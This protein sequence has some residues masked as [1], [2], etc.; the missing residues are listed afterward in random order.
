MQPA[1]KMALR[2]ARQGSEFLK[3]HFERQD[4]AVQD[5]GEA[6]EQLANVEA[7]ISANFTEQL[8]KAY[9]DHYIAPT[10]DIEADGHDASWHVFPVIG[11]ENF[12]RGIPEFVT[13]LVQKKQG[14]AEHLLLINP[15]TGEEYSVSRGHGAALNSRRIRMGG[16]RLIADARLATNVLNFTREGDNPLVWGELITTLA[17]ESTD[18]QTSRCPLLDIARVS[19][20]HLDAAVLF[21][22]DSVTQSLGLLLAHESGGLSGD[23]SGNPSSQES[24]QLV[25]ANPKLFKDVLKSLHSFR[26]RLPR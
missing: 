5:F 19:A 20:G 2:I 4:P 16:A 24:R 8:Q 22:P 9:K 23:F 6:R 15:V 17:S 12:V 3:A 10:G 1:I 25:I 7:S 26:G 14:R 18:V 21:K 13:A 11:S